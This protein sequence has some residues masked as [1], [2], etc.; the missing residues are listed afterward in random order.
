MKIALLQHYQTLCTAL[1]SKQQRAPFIG[2]SK[3]I[4]LF[5]NWFTVWLIKVLEDWH[6]IATC[7]LPYN[8]QVDMLP[9]PLPIV[10]G[11]YDHIM[12]GIN[13]KFNC[14]FYAMFL[15]NLQRLLVWKIGRSKMPPHSN[16]VP[17]NLSPICSYIFSTFAH[18]NPN[19]PT[20][21]HSSVSG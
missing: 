4:H 18:F 2:N 8:R 1:T 21:N 13:S 7:S 11:W 16:P 17:G 14:Y 5:P 6:V 10:E 15:V 19:S 12:C 3:W 20:I 9:I